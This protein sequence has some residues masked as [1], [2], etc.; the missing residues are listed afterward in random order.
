M[1]ISLSEAS[2]GFK[3]PNN[4]YQQPFTSFFSA[5]GA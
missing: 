4:P 3:Y 5:V 2:G 1:L